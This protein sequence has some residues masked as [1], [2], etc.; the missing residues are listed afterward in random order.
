MTDLTRLIERLGLLKPIKPIASEVRFHSLDWARVIGKLRSHCQS[1][2]PATGPHLGP[3]QVGMTLRCDDKVIPGFAEIYDH[4]GGI[5]KTIN[6]ERNN[7]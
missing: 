7:I 5:M 3:I 1:E 2:P 6:L 4:R